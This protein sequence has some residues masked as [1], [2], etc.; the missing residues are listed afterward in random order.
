[1]KALGLLNS[2]SIHPLSDIPHENKSIK[3]TPDRA[4]GKLFAP[5]NIILDASYF[6]STIK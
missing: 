2:N 3:E 4:T 5:V 1:V 6:S